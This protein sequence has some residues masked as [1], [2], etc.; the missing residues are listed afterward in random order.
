MF[1]KHE[2]REPC[3]HSMSAKTH[4]ICQGRQD[5]ELQQSLEEKY[6]PTEENDE[7]G[8]PTERGLGREGPGLD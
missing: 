7:E 4:G 8:L 5:L 2:S 3:Q 1:S 6:E